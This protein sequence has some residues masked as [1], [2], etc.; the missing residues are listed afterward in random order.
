MTELLAS[1]PKLWGDVSLV[2]NGWRACL[3]QHVVEFYQ[4]LRH[5]ARE[6]CGTSPQQLTV[7]GWLLYRRPTGSP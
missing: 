6:A 1:H 2:P 5:F 7:V 3:W 4:V